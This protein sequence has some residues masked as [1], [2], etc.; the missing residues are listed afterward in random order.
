MTDSADVTT[1]DIAGARFSV[2]LPAVVDRLEKNPSTCLVVIGCERCSSICVGIGRKDELS[3]RCCRN[4]G[5]NF[6]GG[7]TY[8]PDDGKGHRGLLFR[9]EFLAQFSL[10][11]KG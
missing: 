4:Y 5:S 1:I 10:A 8:F 6:G 11:T 2:D 7:R 9:D 3:C